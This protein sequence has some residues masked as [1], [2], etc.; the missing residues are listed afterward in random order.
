[1]EFKI[2]CLSCKAEAKLKDNYNNEQVITIRI[3]G[4][5]L[6][7]LKCSNCGNTIITID[8]DIL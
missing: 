3:I 1:M 7:E 5:Q 6:V 2:C 8:G 4:E